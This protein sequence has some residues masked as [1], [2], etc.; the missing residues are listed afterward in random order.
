MRLGWLVLMLYLHIRLQHCPR[1]A[2]HQHIWHTNFA[3]TRKGYVALAPPLTEVGDSAMLV[4]ESRVP[5]ILRRKT[6]T[7]WE[8]IGGANIPGLMNGEQWDEA[9]CETVTIE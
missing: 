9:K 4:K 7:T 6:S 2:R 1:F 5:L 3:R 8:L